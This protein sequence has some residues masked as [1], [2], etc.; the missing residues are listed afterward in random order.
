M[1]ALTPL[2]FGPKHPIAAQTYDATNDTLTKVFTFE[3][4]AGISQID[5]PGVPGTQNIV[6]YLE[7][8]GTIPLTSATINY[9]VNSGTTQSYSWSGNLAVGATDGPITIGTGTFAYGAQSIEAWTSNPNGGT[10][11]NAANDNT[12]ENFTISADIG[13]V[14]GNIQPQENCGRGKRYLKLIC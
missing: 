2:R 3:V 14:G 1:R 4:D 8:F 6:V 9:V 12:L 7:N 5:P 10:D 13:L 11:A